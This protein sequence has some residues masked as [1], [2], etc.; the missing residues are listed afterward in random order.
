MKTTSQ[1]ISMWDTMKITTF[2][3]P[4]FIILTGIHGYY[5]RYHHHWKIYYSC[6][7]KED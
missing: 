7:G 4:M 6:V 3:R 2:S 5:E 1:G